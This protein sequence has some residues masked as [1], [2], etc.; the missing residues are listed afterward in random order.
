MLRKLYSVR[1]AIQLIALSPRQCRSCKRAK[2]C[3][4]RD[5]SCV[6]SYLPPRVPAIIA[7]EVV[8]VGKH[9]P[10]AGIRQLEDH[11]SSVRLRY[12]KS[13]AGSPLNP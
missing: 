10:K 7:I 13:R 9:P 1:L 8:E 12:N 3:C 2:K 4:R 5:C 11:A 6:Q